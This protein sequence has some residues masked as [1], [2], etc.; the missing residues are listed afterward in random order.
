VQSDETP[1]ACSL[2]GRELEQRLDEITALAAESLLGQEADGDRQI[3]RFRSDP[4]TRRQLE[5]LVAAEAECCSFLD[6]RLETGRGE[7]K[8]TVLAPAR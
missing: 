6:F 4:E 3:L 2:R 7:I 1:I 5:A 8:L